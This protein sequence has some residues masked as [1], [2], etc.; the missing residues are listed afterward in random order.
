MKWDRLPQ[1]SRATDSKKPQLEVIMKQIYRT[2]A[3][4]MAALCAIASVHA[5]QPATFP[6]KSIRLVVPQ[7]AGGSSDNLARVIAHRLSEK[8][9]QPVVVDNR[10]GAGGNIGAEIVAKAAPDGYT[11]LLGYLGTQA[12]NGALYTGLTYNPERDL[13]PAASLASVPYVIVANNNLPVRTLSELAARAKTMPV[14]YASAGNGSVNHF[15]GELFNKAAAVKMTHVPYKTAVEAMTST[16]TGQVDIGVI[17]LG[18]TIKQIQAG[19]MRPLAVLTKQRVDA[20]RDVPTAEEAGFPQLTLNA[21]FGL[22]APAGTPAAV[23]RRIS[24]TT[25]EVLKLA[26]ALETI[27]AMGA[28]PSPMSLE[29]FSKLVN[30]DVVRW[31]KIARES[32]VKL[33]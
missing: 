15:I 9:G 17:T 30:D 5:Q 3:L 33:D 11:L 12:L 18:T 26:P 29:A 1:P 32:G 31:G 28:E 7:G 2:V 10:P 6:A 25:T 23:L 14:T 4:A 8:W 24:E 20:L 22:F 21:W 13:V 27:A 19:S 16:M